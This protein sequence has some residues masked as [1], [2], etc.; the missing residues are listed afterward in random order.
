MQALW[1]VLKQIPN[2]FKNVSNDFLRFLNYFFKRQQCSFAC[3]NFFLRFC[4]RFPSASP[5]VDAAYVGHALAAFEMHGSLSRD[6]VK[7]AWEHG[8][9]AGGDSRR[10]TNESVRMM[11]LNSLYCLDATGDSPG[12]LEETDNLCV[13]KLDFPLQDLGRFTH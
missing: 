11:A 9:S 1:R 5:H 13:R 2:V 4:F 7:Y 10:Q 6:V 12:V 8:D 3:L